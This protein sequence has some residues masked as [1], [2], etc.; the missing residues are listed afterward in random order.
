[1][2]R[3]KFL[4][5]VTVFTPLT[6]FLFNHLQPTKSIYIEPVHVWNVNRRYISG[7]E[8]EMSVK[9][10]G[11]VQDKRTNSYGG[12]RPVHSAWNISCY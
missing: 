4:N 6:G 7:I 10:P 8:P 9:I 1:L 5:A 3:L 12:L 11:V 2:P